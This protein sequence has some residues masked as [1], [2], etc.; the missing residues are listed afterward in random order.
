MKR[1][2]EQWMADVDRCLEQK[3]GLTHEDLPDWGYYDA[4][5]DGMTPKGAAIKAIKASDEF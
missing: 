1:S 3:C 2:F 4:Y 5:D